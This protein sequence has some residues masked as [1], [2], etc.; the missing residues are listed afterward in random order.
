LG[1]C[2]ILVLVVA[3]LQRHWEKGS[4][5]SVRSVRVK[6]KIVPLCLPCMP[7]FFEK[8]IYTTLLHLLT[9]SRSFL[10]LTSV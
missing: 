4:R 5:S 1:I 9:L 10:L 2:H 7:H 6:T 8:K 3:Y